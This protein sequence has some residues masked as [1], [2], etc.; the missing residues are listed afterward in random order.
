MWDEGKISVMKTLKGGYSLSVKCVT[1]CKKICWVT[2]VYGPNDYKERRFV[3][4]ELS[5]LS[6]YCSELWCIGEDFNITWWAHERF[7]I[8]RITKGMRKF[9]SFIDSTKLMEVPLS[10]SIYHSLFG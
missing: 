8:K 10:L 3:W 7:P 5:S 9:N 1:F 2:N 4:P 6:I